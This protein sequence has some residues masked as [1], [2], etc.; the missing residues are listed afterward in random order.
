[1]KKIQKKW[2]SHWTLYANEWFTADGQHY[3]SYL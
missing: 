1:M 2:E 3:R